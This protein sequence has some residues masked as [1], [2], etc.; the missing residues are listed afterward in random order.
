MSISREYLFRIYWVASL[1]A[2]AFAY[3]VAVGLFKVFPYRLLQAVAYTGREL[4]R[5]P[6]HTLRLAPEKFL[7]QSPPEGRGV[8]HHVAGKSFPGITLITGFFEGSNGI[9]LIDIDGKLLNEWRLS[10]NEIWP[11]S[12]HLSDQPHDWDTELHGAMLLPNGDVI[13]TYQYGGLVRMD[14]CGQVKWKLPRRTHHQFFADADG[15]LWVPSRKLRDEPVRNYPKIPPPFEEDYILKI[16]PDGVVLAELSILDAIFDSRFEGLLF[17]NGA[18]DSELE[19]P[20]SG[21]FT[22]LNDVE[23]LLPDLAPAF[24]MFEEGDLLVSL[25]N[26]N[27]LMVLSPHSGQI[28]WTQVGPF[29]RQHDPDFLPTGRI[30]VFDNRRDG[31]GANLF[32]GSRILSIDPSTERT[33]TLYGAR[34]GEDFYTDT[35]GEQQ[36]LN[37]GN[38]LI[39]ESDKGH[40]FEIDPNGKIVWSYV[41]RWTNDSVGKISQATRYPDDY[42]SQLPKEAC[43]G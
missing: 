5:S 17:A 23:L 3:G 25:R 35:K 37:N 41:N 19:V 27:L 21:D 12:P 9:R 13:F 36:S 34:K 10:Y 40:A 22:H 11:E 39:S 24:P 2:L 32:G 42:L 43:H 26:L 16:S 8:T 18:H 29:V 14:R 4:I 15:N 30:A 1:C 6:S 7:A 28:K 20:L 33:S 31:S 38:L